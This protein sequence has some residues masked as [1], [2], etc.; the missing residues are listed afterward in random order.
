MKIYNIINEAQDYEG[1]FSF[2]FNI[3]KYLSTKSQENIKNN[4]MNEIE[5][6]KKKY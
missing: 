2:L 1:M 4:V 3:S 6:C 5:Y